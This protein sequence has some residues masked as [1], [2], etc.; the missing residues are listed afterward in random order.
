MLCLHSYNPLFC[1]RLND[2]L[3][4]VPIFEIVYYILICV[5]FITG[6]R[7]VVPPSLSLNGCNIKYAG[8]E[9]KIRELCHMVDQ[10]DLSFNEFQSFAEILKII[11]EIP[12]LRFLN[13]SEND[14]RNV[15]TKGLKPIKLKQME[16]LVLNNCG[17]PFSAVRLLLDSCENLEDLHLSLNNYTT[18]DIGPKKYNNIVRLFISGNPNLTSW[19]EISNLL[20]AFPCLERLT[21]ADCNVD[22]IP[23]DF[24]EILPNL[25]TLNISNWPINKW[26]YLE[27]LNRL[28]TL[29][30]LRC[31]GVKV[32]NQFTDSNCKRHHLIARL[33]RIKRLNGSEITDDERLFAEKE[34][35]RWFLSNGDVNKPERYPS[36][37]T[38]LFDWLNSR[39][40]LLAAILLCYIS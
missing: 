20:D 5:D 38:I 30:E 16:S 17:V 36:Y 23:E 11:K 9:R 18:L 14:F 32:L 21:M 1:L 29:T 13:L 6:N 37:D 34:F 10:L 33:P 28:N 8:P 4:L 35:I 15:N 25:K 39:D 31:Q 19:T 40:I 22:T 7:L 12:N 3:L 24:N 2:I 27:R 26:E